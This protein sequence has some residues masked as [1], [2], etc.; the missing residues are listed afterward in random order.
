MEDARSPDADVAENG[1]RSI[2]GGRMILQ[3]RGCPGEGASIGADIPELSSPRIAP[4]VKD[5]YGLPLFTSSAQ[6]V[7]ARELPGYGPM[8]GCRCFA[9]ARG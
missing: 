2:A 3:I 8:L 1:Y 6:A 4:M 5:A 9:L 7:A